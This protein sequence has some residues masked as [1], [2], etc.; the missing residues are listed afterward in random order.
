MNSCTV[1]YSQMCTHTNTQWGT[2]DLI[3]LVH[4]MGERLKGRRVCFLNSC[5]WLHQAF[6]LLGTWDLK[7]HRT[8]CHPMAEVAVSSATELMISNRS[9]CCL[10]AV[11][12]V[13][14]STCQCGAFCAE[15]NSSSFP[16]S[17][18]QGPGWLVRGCIGLTTWPLRWDCS[19]EC[20]F[21]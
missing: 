4:Y 16:P 6:S 13:T 14:V 5:L 19:V 10:W 7:L 11:V 3:T 17:Y 12:E 21:T 2:E 15:G 18:L 8:Y 20:S 1:L 9:Y